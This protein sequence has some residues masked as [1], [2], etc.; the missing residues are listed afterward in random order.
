MCYVDYSRQDTA[1]IDL[2]CLSEFRRSLPLGVQVTALGVVW[3]DVDSINVSRIAYHDETETLCVLFK[4][5]GL[6][7]Y[8][9][10]DS[11]HYHN[12][13]G[14]SSV[15]RYLSQSIK[16]VYEYELHACEDDMIA[17]INNQ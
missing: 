8:K 9:G 12:L 2:Q 6:Y 1:C 15:G 7:S 16:G 11:D 5:G 13:V 17:S 4:N 14:A 10:V 3:E